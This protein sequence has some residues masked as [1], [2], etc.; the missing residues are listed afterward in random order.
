MISLT[1]QSKISVGPEDPDDL[2]AFFGPSIAREE[3]PA[4]VIVKSAARGLKKDREYALSF[5]EG[6]IVPALK[7]GMRR[8][9]H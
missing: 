1:R 7:S 6:A 9:L 5:T 3:A 4:E 2:P 8:C